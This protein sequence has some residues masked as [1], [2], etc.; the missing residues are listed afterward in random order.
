M[1]CSQIFKCEVPE[2]YLKLASKYPLN[3]PQIFVNISNLKGKVP[4]NACKT[5]FCIFRSDILD[6][7]SF[8][9]HQK[10][11][12][13]M[14]SAY[15]HAEILKLI[16][17]QPYLLSVQVKMQWCCINCHQAT[18]WRQYWWV[19]VVIATAVIIYIVV[20]VLIVSHM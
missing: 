18:F 10:R 4:S 7:P 9:R 14:K 5:Y 20:T 11:I 13:G 8:L 1:F 2:V 19:P 17:N 6:R 3:I 16:M 15:Y 12:N